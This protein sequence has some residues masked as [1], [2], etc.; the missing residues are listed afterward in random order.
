MI[1]FW[2]ALKVWSE[3]IIPAIIC[4][5]VLLIGG[6]AIFTNIFARRRKAKW[7]RENGFER[8]LS[9]V[10]SVGNGAFYAWGNS[11]TGKRIDERDLEHMKFSEL[12][13]RMK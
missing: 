7:L 13:N 2:A 3:F 8:Y 11:K 5:A 4:A 9:D 1:E 6:A 10:P 12:V